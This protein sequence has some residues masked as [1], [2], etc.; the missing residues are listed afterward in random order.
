MWLSNHRN[1]ALGTYALDTLIATE[2]PTVILKGGAMMVAVSGE[3]MRT[4]DDCDILVP[5]ERAPQALAALADAITSDGRSLTGPRARAS[6]AS[7]STLRSIRPL[8]I[9]APQDAQAVLRAYAAACRSQAVDN[10]LNEGRRGV[11]GAPTAAQ[12]WGISQDEYLDK[13]DA[14]PLNPDG[15]LLLGV[16][17]EDNYALANA[18]ENL[19]VPGVGFA[20]WGPVDMSLSLGIRGPY[21]VVLDDPRMV[22]ARAKVLAAC[23]ANK[24]FFLNSMNP[25]DVVA[26]IDEGVM[27]GSTTSQE[28]PK[29]AASTPSGRCHGEFLP[30]GESSSENR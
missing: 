25:D 18:E 24:I 17:L 2:V 29:S 20:E 28:P 14:W 6:R 23:K 27:V 19:K 8:R 13:A 26:M 10:G 30:P 7:P 21:N 1:A 4:M 22:A 11:H 9:L 12:I 15:E 5:V 3:N 16:K